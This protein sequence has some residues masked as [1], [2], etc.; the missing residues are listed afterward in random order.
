MKD[1]SELS[2]CGGDC[3]CEKPVVPSPK[4]GISGRSGIVS[5]GGTKTVEAEAEPDRPLAVLLIV[6]RIVRIEP[7]SER[8]SVSPGAVTDRS[9][10]S[11]EPTFSQIRILKRPDMTYHI[12]LTHLTRS[13]ALSASVSDL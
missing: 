11:L 10:A 8:V 4:S 6:N 7:V 12:A 5:S 13:L 1:V 9:S 3:A 2:D